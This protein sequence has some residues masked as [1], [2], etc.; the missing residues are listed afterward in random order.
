MKK[1]EKGSRC[2]RR[3][4]WYPLIGFVLTL[5]IPESF[6]SQ[7]PLLKQI[8]TVASNWIPA[9]NNLSTVSD[10]PWLTSLYLAVMWMLFPLMV[11]W[12]RVN[13]PYTE[14]LAPMRQCL[15]LLIVTPLVIAFLSTIIYWFPFH[16]DARELGF[17]AGRSGVFLSAILHSRLGLG[18]SFGAFFYLVSLLVMAWLRV[19]WLCVI[20]AFRS[21]GISF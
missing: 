11:W 16:P 5:L 2:Y 1:H 8:I 9:I 7:S 14:T 6:I 17:H 12:W 3:A 19:V 18:L 20:R 15:M 10:F 4:I 13:M 21:I